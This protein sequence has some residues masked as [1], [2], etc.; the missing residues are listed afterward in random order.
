MY[1]YGWV[2]Q[3]DWAAAC[4]IQDEHVALLPVISDCPVQFGLLF[5]DYFVL[6]FNNSL[7]VQG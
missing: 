2:G 1:S 7:S 6:C 3:L 5:T 4:R